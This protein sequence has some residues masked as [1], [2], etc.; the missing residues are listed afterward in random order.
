LARLIFYFFP[1]SV[2]SCVY[3]RSRPV[4]AFS[5]VPSVIR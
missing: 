3:P 1:I 5:I 4:H 2:Y